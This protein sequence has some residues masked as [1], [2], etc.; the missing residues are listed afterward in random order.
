MNSRSYGEN[1][2]SVRQAVAEKNTKDLCGQTNKRADRQTNKQAV[3]DWYLRNHR[4]D[5]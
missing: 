4:L 5:L 3:I 2:F 1:L